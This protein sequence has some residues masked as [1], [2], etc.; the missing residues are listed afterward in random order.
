MIL[1]GLFSLGGGIPTSSIQLRSARQSTG[2]WRF[3]KSVETKADK[4][5]NAASEDVSLSEGNSFTHP[6]IRGG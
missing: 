1:A 2:Y 5:L 3:L 4:D 6:N